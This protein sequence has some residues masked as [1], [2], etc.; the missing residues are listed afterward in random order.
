M[1]WD[2]GCFDA[3]TLDERWERNHEASRRRADLKERAIAYLGG[4]C[5]KCGY[6][7]CP[8]ALD[9]HHLAGREKDFNISSKQSWESIQT[10]LDKCALLCANC[11]R[12]AHAGW[13]P[14]L[15]TLEEGNA[16][17]LH[18]LDWGDDEDDP[19]LASFIEQL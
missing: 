2:P 10:E 1:T 6:D 8:A 12:E 16:G 11:H 18:E 14:D 3:K 13:H 15:L 7:A 17:Y 5:Q 9:F 4:K 19:D